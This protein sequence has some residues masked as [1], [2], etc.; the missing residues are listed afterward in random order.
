MNVQHDQI[1][2]EIYNE[3]VQTIN[4]GEFNLSDFRNHSILFVNTASRCGFTPQYKDLEA[5]YQKY[6]DQFFLIIGFPCNQF[7]KQEPE[8]DDAIHHFCTTNYQ[9]SFP[10]SKKIEVNGPSAHP[11]YKKL[12]QAQPGI[13]NS[14]KIKWNFTK[15]LLMPNASAIFRFSPLSSIDK[16]EAMLQKY[17]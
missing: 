7:G 15:F 12:C 6:K 14:R 1:L 17:I 16:V 13:L 2:A 3:K 11:I 9:V 10:L 5:L 8:K 4:Q